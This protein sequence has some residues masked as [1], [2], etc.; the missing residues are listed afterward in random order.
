MTQ[1][2]LVR[3][4]LIEDDDSHAHMTIRSLKAHRVSNTIARVK[5]GAEAIEYLTGVGRYTDRELP[6]VI[7]LDLKLP[8]VEG[9]EVL[10]RI[11]KDPELHRIP[12]VVLTT[13]NAE[14]DRLKAYDLHA[15][16]YVVKPLDFQCFTEL[17]K[18][19]SLYWGVWNE[20][21]AEN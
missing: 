7:L 10:A 8:K 6:D 11:K 14:R 15:N 13:S 3:F 18:D 12:V 4:L 21:P 1:T 16:S 20:K 19:L 17:I 5:D 9:H 2:N